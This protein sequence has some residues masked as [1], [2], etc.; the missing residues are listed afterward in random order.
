MS[1][2]RSR[3]IQ[4]SKPMRRKSA[5][6]IAR[7][8]PEERAYKAWVR[9]R[10]C[11]VG[12]YLVFHDCEGRIEQSHERN[13]TGLGLKASN[14]R[15]VAMCS[16][17]HRDWEQHRGAFKGWTREAR[18]TWMTACIVAEHSDFYGERAA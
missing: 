15:S 14:L 3:P 11:V 16:R 10:P 7:E 12:R 5:R 8:T 18:L 2:S 13:R 17:G 4:R 1:L 6:R 9:N